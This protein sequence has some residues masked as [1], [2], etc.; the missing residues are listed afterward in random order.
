MFIESDTTGAFELAASEVSADLGAREKYR[1]IQFQL[2]HQKITGKSVKFSTLISRQAD[3][4]FDILQ[5]EG[6][7]GRSR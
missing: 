3:F 6:P 1:D 4:S 7:K 2:S 5:R